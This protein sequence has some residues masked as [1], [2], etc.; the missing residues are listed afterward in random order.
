MQMGIC[1]EFL[2]KINYYSLLIMKALAD[3]DLARVDAVHE[4]EILQY[5]DDNMIIGDNNDNTPGMI[6]G[7]MSGAYLYHE[8]YQSNMQPCPHFINTEHTRFGFI[9]LQCC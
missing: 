6:T 4:G 8:L 3:I 9:I 1:L 5:W 7:R 2:L